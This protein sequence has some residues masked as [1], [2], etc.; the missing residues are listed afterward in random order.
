VVD[1]LQEQWPAAVGDAGQA[2]NDHIVDETAESVGGNRIDQGIRIEHLEKMPETLAL[3]LDAEL[4]IVLQGLPVEVDIVVERDAVQTEVGPQ[5]AFSR[6]A[7]DL[8]ALDVVD[9]GGAERA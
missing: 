8:A 5:D 7:I 4:A 6:P 9:G 3:G 1:H 2:S